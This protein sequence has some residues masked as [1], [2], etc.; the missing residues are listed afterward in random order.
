MQMYV[1]G[2]YVIGW[3]FLKNVVWAA[4]KDG[5][6]VETFREKYQQFTHDTTSEESWK[7]SRARQKALKRIAIENA[8]FHAIV[9]PLVSLICMFA[10]DD[11]NKNKL[12]L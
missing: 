6:K 4:M 3:Q 7:L 12:A 10:D 2:Q 11:D 9:V 8:V 1:Q 5:F